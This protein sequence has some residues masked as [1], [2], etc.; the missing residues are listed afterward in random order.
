MEVCWPE[1]ELSRASLLRRRAVADERAV[2]P[3]LGTA[4][5]ATAD[6]PDSIQ[7][8]ARLPRLTNCEILYGVLEFTSTTEDGNLEWPYNSPPA[9]SACVNGP[10]R[11]SFY[12]LFLTRTGQ[13]MPYQEAA[14]YTWLKCF[15]AFQR[16]DDPPLQLG[17]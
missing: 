11:W 13:W 15:A 12:C 9:P 17:W 3:H 6:A 16:G 2:T 14:I 10:Q 5:T 1:T 7:A 4:R 8:A